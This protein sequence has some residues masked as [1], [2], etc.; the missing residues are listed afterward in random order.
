MTALFRRLPPK[1]E[2]FPVYAILVF[3]IFSWA[4][5]RFFWYLPSWLEYLSLPAVLVVL[6]YSLAFALFESLVM[7][8]VF[9][10]LNLC[11]PAALFRRHFVAQGSL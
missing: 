7:M 2:I 8:G 1:N 9:L 11:L 5:Y 3:L 10:L 4:L 6:S